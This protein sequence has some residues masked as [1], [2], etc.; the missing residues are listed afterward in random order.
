MLLAEIYLSPKYGASIFNLLRVIPQKDYGKAFN[1][2]IKKLKPCASVISYHKA[3]SVTLFWKNRGEGAIV[4]NIPPSQSVYLEGKVFWKIGLNENAIP[5]LFVILHHWLH[6]FTRPRNV[7]FVLKLNRKF[8]D[9]QIK[10][11]D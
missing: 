10:T 6:Y 8:C 5:S 2:R 9:Q 4:L 11:S 3:G 7:F 1:D